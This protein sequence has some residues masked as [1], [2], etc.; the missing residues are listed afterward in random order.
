MINPK[1]QELVLH[2]EKMSPH[3][4]PYRSVKSHSLTDNFGKYLYERLPEYH[5]SLDNELGNPLE[6]FIQVLEYGGFLPTNYEIVDLVN[7]SQ[8]SNCPEEYLEHKGFALGADWISEVD[9]KYK[10]KLLSLLVKL[11]KKKGTTDVI[12]YIASE[13]SG[14][15]VTVHENF[16]PSEF[17]EE[18]DPLKRCLTVYLHA[19][20]GGSVN[21]DSAKNIRFI[22]SHFIPVH[23][24]LI[25]LVTYFVEEE[26]RGEYLEEDSLSIRND[27]TTSYNSAVKY[28]ENTSIALKDNY[29]YNYNYTEGDTTP[30][31]CSTKHLLGST[32]KVSPFS[33]NYE[34]VTITKNGAKTIQFI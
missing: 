26:Y 1:A 27:Y 5:R 15:N 25:I 31:L 28:T 24:K 12:R 32:F 34:K 10:R 16:I 18:D 3:I 29:I 4:N 14:V 9:P 13:V 19:P 7:L 23:S 20:E 2:Q 33:N 30:I 8:I 11:Y 6:K 21:N 22:A 17:A